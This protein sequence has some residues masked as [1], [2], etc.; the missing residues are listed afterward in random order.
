MR[1]NRSLQ[2]AAVA[3]SAACKS[4]MPAASVYAATNDFS[5]R[6]RGELSTVDRLARNRRNFGSCPFSP[7]LF[8]VAT[9]SDETFCHRL[10]VAGRFA[11]R[12]GTTTRRATHARSDLPMASPPAKH[13]RRAVRTGR[14]APL[15]SSASHHTGAEKVVR[16]P[17]SP[18][19]PNRERT[20]PIA[21]RG[22]PRFLTRI[23]RDL[24]KDLRPSRAEVETCARL[25]MRY[26]RG[27]LV[28]LPRYRREA[29]VHLWISRCLKDPRATALLPKVLAA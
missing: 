24:P 19:R 23:L 6:V 27:G 28:D 4:T 15:Q 13:H 21:K 5:P 18:S 22:G 9:S 3:F 8:L 25:I 1:S 12:P 7:N 26:E 14:S 29:R 2:N 10:L 16:A 20:G 17:A 11:P